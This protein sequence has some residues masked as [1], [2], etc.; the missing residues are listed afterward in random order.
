MQTLKPTARMLWVGLAC[1]LAI[2]LVA[3]CDGDSTS[4]LAPTPTVAA[5][6][7]TPTLVPATPTPRPTMAPAPA[8]NIP[9]PTPAA[10]PTQAPTPTMAPPQASNTPLPTVALTPSQAVQTENDAGTSPSSTPAPEP[11]ITAALLEQHRENSRELL[12]PRFDHDAALLDDGRVLLGGGHTAIGDYYVINPTPLGLV[13]IYDPE[14]DVWTVIDPVQGPGAMYSLF[15]LPDG[16]LLALGV[17]ASKDELKS[18]AAVFDSATGLWSEL[19]G[20]PDVIRGSPAVF[21]LDD[22]RVLVAGGLNLFSDPSA[23][24]S[25]AY[26]EAFEIFDPATGQWQRAANPSKPFEPE[27]NRAQPVFLQL[28]DGRVVAFGSEVSDRREYVPHAEV[29][30][31]ASDTW[32]PIS[33]LDPYFAI[34]GGVALS[35]GRLLLHGRVSGPAQYETAS[36]GEL[37]GPYRIYNPS[38]DTWTPTGEPIYSRPI[39]PTLSLLPNGRVLVAGGEKRWLS[40]QMNRYLRDWAGDTG[41]ARLELPHSTSEIYDPETNSWS[42]GP[43]LKEARYHSTGTVLADG[44]VLLAGGFSI[45]QEVD[46]INPYPLSTS[47]IVDPN[48]SPGTAP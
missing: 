1:L 43:D 16:R 45:N 20:S 10:S 5:P 9:F 39:F 6:V 33:G 14:S 11:T 19:P 46:E 47:E 22:G 4:S 27:F 17:A 7:I 41:G 44:R 29:Y 42:L 40:E 3:A 24:Y 48:G 31:S 23:G 35:D 38:N 2:A 13:E 26:L 30:D 28:V 37:F 34:H 36:N 12:Y 21:L 18:M 15:R 25:P 32:T 8:S